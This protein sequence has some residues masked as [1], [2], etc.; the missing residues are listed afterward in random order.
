[1]PIHYEPAGQTFVTK[2][3]GDPE[4]A[5]RELGFRTAIDLH[6]GLKRLIAW[7]REHKDQLAARQ[8]RS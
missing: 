2:R 3:V 8:A 5:A 1:M 7:R 6:D 4:K